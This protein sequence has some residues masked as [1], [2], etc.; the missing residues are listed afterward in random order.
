MGSC[1][2]QFQEVVN[3]ARRIREI[4]R[5]LQKDHRQLDCPKV[6][7]LLLGSGES[8]KSTVL[9][10]LNKLYSDSHP[11]TPEF[12]Q[13]QRNKVYRT[14]VQN[15]IILLEHALPK[16]ESLE[17][18][19]RQGF[20]TDS[21]QCSD[22]KDTNSALQGREELLAVAA[23]FKKV[24]LAEGDN[25]VITPSI[26]G[27]IGRLWKDPLIQRTWKKR[28]QFQILDAL[29]FYC[30]SIERIAAEVYVPSFDDILRIRIKTVG[31]DEQCYFFDRVQFYIYDV[32]GQRNQRSKW[33]H[34]FDNVTAVMFVAAINEY[35]QTLAEDRK[36]N[37]MS[38]SL[39]LF[40]EVCQLK[41]FE[42]SG[43]ILFLN[44]TDLFREKLN[45]SPYAP[46]IRKI[47][48][49][50]DPEFDGPVCQPDHPSSEIGTPEFENCY[51]AAM[52][53]STKLF[54]T[55]SDGRDV[56]YHETCA[57]DTESVKVIFK[58]CRYVICTQWLLG[59]RPNSF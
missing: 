56:F 26:G 21:E 59:T 49:A 38:E 36:T 22:K 9:K 20:S 54:T 33:I 44:K 30:D 11:Y 17:D 50:D 7:L 52:Q 28:F 46:A 10:Q 53:Y 15:M 19:Q 55:R 32:G 12:F 18:P 1:F 16:A 3:E 5:R 13:S 35:D 31:I 24:A 27:M 47:K 4:E 57:T 41:W 34:T 8:G 23:E 29:R 2:S 42:K 58:S 25:I 48:K 39:N 40:Q 37:R 43:I 14:I 6:K 51:L 45:Y